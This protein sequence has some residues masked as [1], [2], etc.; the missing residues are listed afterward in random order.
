MYRVYTQCAYNATADHAEALKFGQA[1]VAYG[2]VMFLGPGGSGKS[3]LLDGLTNKSLRLGDSTALADILNIKHHLVEAADAAED[4][5]RVMAEEDEV[6]ELESLSHLALKE[7][8][9]RPW[10][11][12]TRG[13]VPILSA[14]VSF[15]NQIARDAAQIQE[16][17]TKKVIQR[18]WQKKQELELGLQQ[19]T[20]LQPEFPLTHPLPSK[21]QEV[22]M[23]IWD[24]GGQP[25]FLDIL[26][27]FLT[28]RTM[29]F[30]IFNASLPLNSKCQESWRCKG[31]IYQG[32]ELNITFL[33]LIMQWMRLIDASLVI[34]NEAIK[35]A[36][37][38]QSEATTE[39]KQPISCPRIMIVG[40]HGD[41]VSSLQ[42][43]QVL[44][45]LESS[46]R[47]RAFRDLLIDKLIIDNTT[48]GSG[49]SEDRGYRRIRKT[50][51][52]F[53]HSL[54]APTP[55]A[56]VSF[57]KVVQKAAANSPVLSYEH[58]STIAEACGIAQ[59]MVPSVLHFYHQLG[60]FL[61]YKA[62]ESLSTTIIAEPQWLIKQLCR[63]LLPKWYHPRPQNLANLWECL[64]KKGIL[65]ED[66]YQSVWRHCGL[67]GGAKALVDLLEHF[68]LAAKIS[69]VPKEIERYKGCKYFVPCLLKA[70]S[71]KYSDDQKK[72]M[73]G[74]SQEF[75]PKAATL[76]I[77][78]NTGYIPPGFFIRLAARM[79]KSEK[80]IP[81][82]GRDIY[83]DSITFC[84]EEIDR[85]TITESKTL[86][87][88]HVDIT[89]VAKRTHDKIRFADSC[90]SF[91]NE[92]S[93][94]CKEVLC[95][96][97]SIELDFAFRCRCTATTVEHFATIDDK[98]NRNSQLFCHQDTLYQMY[99]EH[100]YW[101]P[102][103]PLTQQVSTVLPV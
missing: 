22:V 65:L 46:C 98:K 68:D 103:A 11:A 23:H 39:K 3:S 14:G 96:L 62:I 25:V 67:E 7:K 82:F 54:T 61:H 52:E 83:R 58:V 100:K 66:L 24:C 81:V 42:A 8:T 80:C 75:S 85:V 88:I 53:T 94:M 91:R 90:V 59:S 99:P 43:E 87:S 28:S 45:E 78:F 27:A 50:V 10:G 15:S 35:A 69:P 93:A 21:G 70:E 97:P 84:Y 71:Q 63:L 29:F 20:W 26:S 37:A 102:P 57:R 19:L 1:P 101:L 48:A 79:T 40:T 55:L 76:H 31:R 56:W 4:A 16:D 30:L 64:E 77:T 44:N 47:D 36:A 32:K 95:W 2:R 18:A 89:R 5:W 92:L 17:I 41:K 72:R 60:V 38:T 73:A 74:Q 12:A 33:Q 86:V 9:E 13:T 51:H 49:R 34:K 6:Q